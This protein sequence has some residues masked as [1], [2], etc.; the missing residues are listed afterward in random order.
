[1]PI[2][3]IQYIFCLEGEWD[4]TL[5]SKSSILPTLEFLEHTAGIKFLFR[6]VALTDDLFFYLDKAVKAEYK[7]YSIIHLAF[8]GKSQQIFMADNSTVNIKELAD[9]YKGKFRGRV[10]HFGSC[11]TLKTSPENLEYFLKTTEAE[12]VSGY[13]TDVDFIDSSI[14]EIAYFTWLQEYKQIWRVNE[15]LKENYPGLYE[16]LGFRAFSKR[17]IV[18]SKE[19]ELAAAE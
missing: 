9:A 5:K 14:F 19:E 16:R 10:V 12:L 1:M 18:K 11:K 6:K 17:D 8:H 13:T 7:K 15:E 2:A 3:Y 4:D